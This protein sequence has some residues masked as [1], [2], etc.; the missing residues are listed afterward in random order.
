MS[1]D[2]WYMLPSNVEVNVVLSS[3]GA[4]RHKGAMVYGTG[5]WTGD[6]GGHRLARSSRL[7]HLHFAKSMYSGR[8]SI[9][10]VQLNCKKRMR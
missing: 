3:G 7:A 8:F 10:W 5:V 1:A 2:F 6:G 9:A 4:G